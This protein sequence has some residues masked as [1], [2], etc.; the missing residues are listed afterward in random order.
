MVSCEEVFEKVMECRDSV[1]MPHVHAVTA[2]GWEVLYSGPPS[3]ASEKM[4]Q[5]LRADVEVEV[6]DLHQPKPYAP[7]FT[8]FGTPFFVGFSFLI[9]AIVDLVV[10]FVLRFHIVIRNVREN[11]GRPPMFYQGMLRFRGW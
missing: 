8:G 11:E 3:G 6:R 7:L 4:A 5:A 2:R 1:A 10:W 9:A